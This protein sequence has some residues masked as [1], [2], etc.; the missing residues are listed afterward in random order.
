M[1]NKSSKYKNL[2][3]NN[4]VNSQTNLKIVLYK[5]ATKI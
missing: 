4:K 2:N 5:L 3:Y 1:T